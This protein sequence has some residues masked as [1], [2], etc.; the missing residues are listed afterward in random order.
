M[1]A[2][3]SKRDLLVFMMGT[4]MG[5]AIVG[6]MAFKIASL[7]NWQEIVTDKIDKILWEDTSTRSGLRNYR[8]VNYSQFRQQQVPREN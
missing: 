5:A 1:I 4:T 3:V 6:K 2:E 7:I 8:T